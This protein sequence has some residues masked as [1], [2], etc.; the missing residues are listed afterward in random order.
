M[1]V[2]VTSVQPYWDLTF[3]A[4]GDPDP[5]LRDTLLSAVRECTDLVLFSHGW[6]NDLSTASALYDRFFGFFPALLPAA[7]AA[8]FGYAGVHWPSMRFSDEPIPDFPHTA[9]A[10]AARQDA[11][12]DG[13]PLDA[14]TLAAL[15]RVFPGHDADIRRMD[16]LLAE[17]PAEP[18][19]LAE[20]AGLVRHVT[21]VAAPPAR[22]GNWTEDLGVPPG[23]L[24]V[25]A[26]ADP[27]ALC[28]ALAD[29]LDL[30][31]APVA[32][33]EA[34]PGQEPPEPGLPFGLGGIG[35]IGTRVWDGA[36]ELLRQATYYAMKK[37]AG[38]VGQ[39]GLGPVLGD[40]ARKAPGVR[41]HLVGHSFGARLVSFALAGMPDGTRVR[42]LTL[43]QGAFSHY[44]FSGGLPFDA[45]GGVLHGMQSRVA[46]PV[47]ACHSRY[48]QALGVLYPLASR[49]AGEDRS[50]LGLGSGT[51]WGAIGHDG[52]QSLPGTA[53]LSLAEALAEASLPA[54]CVSVD[55]SDVVRRGGPPAGA[56]SDICHEELA[57][58]VLRAGGH[59]A[60]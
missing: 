41:I 51:R 4:D 54:G 15:A 47:V 19:R 31:G 20:F 57:R 37:R 26:T 58:L 16:Q 1:A 48:D 42:S 35:R 30:T 5:R 45:R 12:P 32:P 8:G 52:F 33:A 40:I 23:A 27:A 50:F 36:K 29:A 38:T 21:G 28:G 2:T 59:P 34:G 6:N 7:T 60:G 56:H 55:A 18:E 43:I 39:A 22:A 10:A 11:P 44:T 49:M 13:R 25:L 9:A 46:G 53:Q 3:D 14:A 17:R 24:P